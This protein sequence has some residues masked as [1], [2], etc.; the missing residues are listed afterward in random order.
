MGFSIVEIFG[1]FYVSNFSE[2]IGGKSLIGAGFREL[3]DRSWR[4]GS[5]ENSSMAFG[6]RGE[7]RNG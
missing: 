1:D 6:C 2:I 4:Q 7:Q 3:A 5:N